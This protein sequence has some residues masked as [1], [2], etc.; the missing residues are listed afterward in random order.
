MGERLRVPLTERDTL[1][2]EE[3]VVVALTVTVALA[4]QIP[5]TNTAPGCAAALHPTGLL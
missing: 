5:V 1:A 2:E 4:G 3:E